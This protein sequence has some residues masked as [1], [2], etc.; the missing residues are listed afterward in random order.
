MGKVVD[1]PAPA[2]SAEQSPVR[3]SPRQI[4]AALNRLCK[5]GDVAAAWRSLHALQ[6]DTVEVNLIHYNTVMSGSQRAS[7]WQLAL[8][9]FSDLGRHRFP[10][11]VRSYST[12]LQ[13]C[14]EGSHWQAALAL[15]KSSTVKS[16]LPDI[17]LAT[18][19]RFNGRPPK[20]LATVLCCLK[21]GSYGKSCLFRAFWSTTGECHFA[22]SG[23]NLYALGLRLLLSLCRE[24]DFGSDYYGHG[25]H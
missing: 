4:T 1:S 10:G 24:T 12:A 14:G 6:E 2:I 3:R 5:R 9:L 21:C 20:V 18:G 22:V 13:A 7:N 19:F 17:V 15:L 11:D 25:K 8:E 16:V 23:G